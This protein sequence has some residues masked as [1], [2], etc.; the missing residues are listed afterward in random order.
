LGIVTG[1]LN[2]VQLNI[3][4]LVMNDG[5]LNIV[6]GELK[7]VQNAMKAESIIERLL[8]M[9]MGWSYEVQFIKKAIPI[10]LILLDN[11]IG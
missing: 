4:E 2:E 6:T 7:L 5:V 10:L 11:I 3:N 1:W 9:L 8:G